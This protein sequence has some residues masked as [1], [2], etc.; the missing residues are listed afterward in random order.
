MVATK[1]HLFES[2][3]LN[4]YRKLNNK[5]NWLLQKVKQYKSVVKIYQLDQLALERGYEIIRLP[6]YHCQYN[7]IEL[8]WAKV[9]GE[10]AAEN[11]TFFLAD[12]EHLMHKVLDRVTIVDWA[13]H[14][15]HAEKLQDDDYHKE[16]ARDSVINN[17]IINL[18]DTDSDEKDESD[19]EDEEDEEEVLATSL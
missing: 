5:K 14:V 13:G 2:V 3:K 11:K 4:Y 7:L 15:A 19:T 8:I 6:P 1:Y 9:K 17:L 16:V 18:E 10:V 12:M